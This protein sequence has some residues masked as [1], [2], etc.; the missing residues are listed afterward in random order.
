MRFSRC[1]AS[2]P[3]IVAE[4]GLGH[5]GFLRMARTRRWRP[6]GKA[7]PRAVK[8]PREAP[9]YPH[10]V[11]VN[12]S[13]RVKDFDPPSPTTMAQGPGGV[14]AAL[15]GISQLRLVAVL[16][17]MVPF[18]S[19]PAALVILTRLTTSRLVPVS[20]SF[21]GE[22]LAFAYDVGSNFVTVGEF[23]AASFAASPP[24]FAA[25]VAVPAPR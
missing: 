15:T 16:E 23:A 18:D 12:F 6:D 8:G 11:I 21:I 20:W 13:G 9:R 10:Q 14:V 17:T 22:P 7:A 24:A 3:G 1:D 2:S 25:V 4:A 19:A 5:E